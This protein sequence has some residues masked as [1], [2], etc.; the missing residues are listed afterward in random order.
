MQLGDKVLVDEYSSDSKKSVNQIT[1]E[2]LLG[3]EIILPGKELNRKEKEIVLGALS[4]FDLKDRANWERLGKTEEEREKSFKLDK[5]QV[6]RWMSATGTPDWT[7]YRGKGPPNYKDNDLTDYFLQLT[8]EIVNIGYDGLDDH[9]KLQFLLFCLLGVGEKMDHIWI[10]PMKKKINK[11]KLNE[12]IESDINKNNNFNQEI[13]KQNMLMADEFIPEMTIP[14]NLIYL[15]GRLNGINTRIMI[16]TGAS[17]CVIFK[18]IVDKCG[19]GYL[20]DSSTSVMVQG[21]HGM[22]PTLG[23]IWFAEIEIEIDTDK[24]VS[25]PISVEVI[26]DSETIKTKQIIKE[27]YEKINEII[28]VNRYC[29]KCCNLI[30]PPASF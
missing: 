25:I 26:D 15:K 14:T 8:N 11:N 13:I 30:G 12:I 18:S 23:T 9:P 3:T 28:G 22:K 29:F 7:S 24:W 21:A 5:F 1:K 6:L 16:D 4:L 20:V 2:D 10:S 17:S 27:H 19:L